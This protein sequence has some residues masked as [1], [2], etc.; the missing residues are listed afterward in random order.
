D[1]EIAEKKGSITAREAARQKAAVEVQAVTD[2]A[3][4]KQKD[5]DAHAEML[6][7]QSRSANTENEDAQSAFQAAQ[8]KINKSP[9]GRDR[10]HQLA[11]VEKTEKELETQLADAKKKYT[12]SLT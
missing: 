1:I 2:K 3:N 4:A 5:F 11:E 8:D 10:A 9:G 12:D 6:R 7:L